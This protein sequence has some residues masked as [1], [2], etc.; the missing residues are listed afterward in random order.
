ML[1]S[2]LRS[3][4]PTTKPI[5]LKLGKDTFT[6]NPSKVVKLF[7]ERLFSAPAGFNRDRAKALLSPFE[8]PPVPH[9]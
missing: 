3:S 8:L 6:T 5:T 7:T 1:A 9:P 2:R 4:D